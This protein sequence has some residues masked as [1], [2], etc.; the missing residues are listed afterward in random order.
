MPALLA[1]ITPRG[2]LVLAG[3]ALALVVVVF[4]GMQVA[5]RPSFALVSSGMDPAETGKVAAVLDEQGIV[6]ELRNN[7]TA[8]AVEKSQTAQARIALAGAG[9]GGGSSAQ[10]GW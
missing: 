6:Y 8:L 9:L 1:N 5:G 4:F 3:C 2:R 7:G 10:P